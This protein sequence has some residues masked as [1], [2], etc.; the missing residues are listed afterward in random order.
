MRLRPILVLLFFVCVTAHAERQ[1]PAAAVASAHPAATAAGR[2]ILDAGGNAF[3]AAVAVAAALAVVEPYASGIGGGGFFLL[4]RARDAHDV[5]IDARERAPGA[6]SANMYLDENGRPI[7]RLSLDGPLAAAIP[8]TPA[9]LVH[10]AKNYGVLPLS[11]SLA[12]AVRLAKNGFAVGPRYRRMAEN[13]RN[14]LL[15]WG[16]A[17]VFLDGER[18]PELGHTVRQPDLARTLELLG[19]K[20][21]AGFYEG[22]TARRLVEGIRAAGGIWTAADLKQYRVVERPPLRATYRG[23]RIVASPLPSSGGVLLLEMLGMLEHFDLAQ[24]PPAERTHVLIEAM[25]RAYR[26]RAVHLGDPDFIARELPAR[27]L[28]PKRLT[29]LGRSIDRGRATPSAELAPKAPPAPRGGTDTTH[30]SIID[31]AGNRVAATLSINIP[32]GSGFL[33]RG[34]GVLLNNEMDDFA[35]APDTPNTY[36]LVGREANLIAPGKRPLSSMTPTFVETRDAV[37]ILGTPGGSRIVS[38]VLL[39]VLDAVHSPLDAARWISRPRFHHQY[40][41][42]RVS[43]EPD[44][45]NHEAADSLK[46]K[47]HVLNPTADRYGNMQIVVWDRGTRR[48]E[49]AADPRG[50]GEAVVFVPMKKR[51][52]AAAGTR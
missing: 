29:E 45:F 15:K 3:D 21:S 18:A 28:D 14:A 20:G 49:A 39:G 16:G 36:G 42:D 5:M 1:P 24:L 25:R 48:V 33:A 52:P 31:A 46:G 26:D 38:M 34:T 37:V 13:R 40:L 43:H 47:G 27:L 12:P 32:F 2:E 30:Y 9:G 10:L 51:V 23:A 4:H 11:R 41:P 22:E 19:A 35:M 6:A 7:P 17:D 8:G 50:E 44:A